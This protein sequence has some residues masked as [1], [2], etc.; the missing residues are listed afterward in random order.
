[1]I[2][3][4]RAKDCS[5]LDSM[6]GITFYRLSSFL[7]YAPSDFRDSTKPSSLFSLSY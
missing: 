3:S 2:A 5:S 4:M 6:R 1:L 7:P